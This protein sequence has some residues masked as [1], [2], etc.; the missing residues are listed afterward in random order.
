MWEHMLEI[1]DQ[2]NVSYED[3]IKCMLISV[4]YNFQYK[5]LP[6]HGAM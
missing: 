2:I 5:G 1:Q 3:N 4:T 6:Q